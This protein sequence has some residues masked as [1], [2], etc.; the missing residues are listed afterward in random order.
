MGNLSLTGEDISNLEILQ[1]TVIHIILGDQYR[2]YTSAL[3][4]TRNP[5][6]AEQNI[7]HKVCQEG[8]EVPLVGHMVQT[9]H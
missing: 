6:F 7:L 4:I 9:K 5:K 1:K 3:K 2:S 8:P